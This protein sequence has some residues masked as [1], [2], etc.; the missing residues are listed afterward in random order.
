M[1]QADVQRVPQDVARNAGSRRARRPR[2]LPR[3]IAYIRF[4]AEMNN[5]TFNVLVEAMSSVI[6]EE[7]NCRDGYVYDDLAKDMAIAAR[8]VYDA[9]L[10]SSVFT[11]RESA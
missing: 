2:N 1:A 10:K 4:G 6:D 3:D 7:N 5:R 8:A 11:E 9:C